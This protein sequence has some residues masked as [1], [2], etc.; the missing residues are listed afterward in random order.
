MRARTRVLLALIVPFAM[1]ASAAVR[2]E[3]ASADAQPAEAVWKVQSFDFSYGG[4]AT[5]YS[6][7]AL[8]KRVRSILM[9]MGAHESIEVRTNGCYDLSD[10]A[11]LRITMASPV[12][13][14]PENVRALTQY[15]AKD[16]LIARV[17]GET[18]GSAA[19]LERFA[20]EW[21]TISLARDQKLKLAPGDCELIEQLRRDVLPRMSVRV[22][23]DNLRC[24]RAFGSYTR[25][26][27]TVF[28]LVPVAPNER[29]ASL[30]PA[31]EWLIAQR[32]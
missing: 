32:R 14:T 2:A 29:Q 23:E 21:R 16:E 4:L 6:C 15:D 17:R 5:S 10:F 7:G 11:T 1:L 26:Q 24:S 31:R 30:T 28:A 20:A 27:L 19:D 25:P 13:A 12:E 18:L 3:A 8:R 9:R 22:V